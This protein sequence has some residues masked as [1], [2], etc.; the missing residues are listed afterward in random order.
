MPRSSAVSISISNEITR[1]VEAPLAFFWA[2][3]VKGGIK[4]VVADDR[5]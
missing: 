3:L 1:V 4:P 2:L 5:Q